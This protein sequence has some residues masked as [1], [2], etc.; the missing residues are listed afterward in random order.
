[1]DNQINSFKSKLGVENNGDNLVKLS[2]RTYLILALIALDIIA[3]FVVLVVLKKY[4]YYASTLGLV[5]G[6]LLGNLLRTPEEKQNQL[7][8]KYDLL[9][10]ILIAAFS[11]FTIFLLANLAL[12]LFNIMT[13]PGLFLVLLF[14]DLVIGVSFAA[15]QADRKSNWEREHQTRSQINS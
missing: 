8:P 6:L 7:K 10:I 4:S 9:S 12:N 11:I 3:S 15:Y 1:M 5:L 14:F 13:I 2:R